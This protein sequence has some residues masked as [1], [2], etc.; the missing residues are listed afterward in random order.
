MLCSSFVDPISLA[1]VQS[2]ESKKTTKIA[3]EVDQ[4]KLQ[5]EAKQSTEGADFYKNEISGSQKF[6]AVS[7]SQSSTYLLSGD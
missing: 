4:N 5:E 7:T 3:S 1:D 2:V 6:L